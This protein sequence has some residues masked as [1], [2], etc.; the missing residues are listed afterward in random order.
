[1]VRKR[2]RKL[3]SVSIGQ[4]SVL[5]SS[6]GVDEWRK[7]V[8]AGYKKAEEWTDHWSKWCPYESHHRKMTKEQQASLTQSFRIKW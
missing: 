6:W 8:R 1:M 2:N 7:W 5:R 4:R 3:L